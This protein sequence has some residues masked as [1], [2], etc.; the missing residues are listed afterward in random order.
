MEPPRDRGESK[1]K[2]RKKEMGEWRVAKPRRERRKIERSQS[3]QETRARKQPEQQL[4][5]V[6]ASQ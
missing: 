3:V 5:D 4:G 6:K 1:Q 2:E